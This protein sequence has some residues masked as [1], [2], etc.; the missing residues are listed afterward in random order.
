MDSD[1]FRQK[2]FLTLNIKS[3]KTMEDQSN[4]SQEQN[5]KPYPYQN[6]EL[7]EALAKAEAEMEEA[8]KDYI[9][10]RDREKK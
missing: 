10:F 8:M 1:I 6:V 7:R 5:S 9:P 2:I 4:I 3:R